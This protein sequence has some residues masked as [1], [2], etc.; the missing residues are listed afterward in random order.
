MQFWP[1][2]RAR[3]PYAR[4]K[5]WSN[6]N[7]TKLLGF[8]GYKAGMTHVMV[9]DN[10]PNSMTKGETIFCPVTIIECP[11]LRPYSLRF[12]KKTVNGHKLVS[13]I[14][15]KNFDKH[16]RRKVIPSKKE[17]KQPEDFDIVRLAV[18]T[19]PNMVSLKKTPELFELGIGGKDVKEKAAYALGL[20]DKEIK[21]TDVL[22]EGQFVDTHSVSKAKG[23]QGPVKRFGVRIRQHK[24]EKTKRGP[25]TLGSWHPN[26]VDFRV[27]HAGKM[28]FHLRTE[29]NKLV[30]KIG[31]DPKEI[32][33]KGGFLNYGVVKNEYVM[34]KGSVAGTRKRLIT[35][36][37]PTRA[38]VKPPQY[39]IDSISLSSKQ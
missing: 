3:R 7:E 1:R 13:E 35:L 10:S 24:A 28:G 9:D 30:V 23:T 32:A 31:N 36:T 16:I 4:I 26:R 20:L 11:P 18:Y 33:V 38:L 29:H 6:I 34:V 27:A 25:A 37:E 22:K 14:F 5:I 2:C 21:V 15:A 8:A 17:G 19:Q 39:T 12:Y